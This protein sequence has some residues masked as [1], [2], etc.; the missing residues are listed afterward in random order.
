MHPVCCK[1]K[2]TLILRILIIVDAFYINLLILMVLK[3]FFIAIFRVVKIWDLRRTYVV[4]S[5]YLPTPKYK[6]DY[7][8][9]QGKRKKMKSNKLFFFLFL[10]CIC[11]F[12]TLI[13][14]FTL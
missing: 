3:L 10:I 2:Y 4:N 7:G 12:L 5:K 14:N 8:E 9:G 13:F 6:M 11:L 1:E